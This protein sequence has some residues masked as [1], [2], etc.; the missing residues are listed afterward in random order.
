MLRH[1]AALGEKLIEIGQLYFCSPLFSIG[2]P[3][4]ALER[5][6]KFQIYCS[7]YFSRP[8]E[9]MRESTYSMPYSPISAFIM[10]LTRS[11]ARTKKH[12]GQGG[13]GA[14]I[15]LLELLTW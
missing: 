11:M 8:N 5:R 4:A 12:P 10:H 6:K 7:M 2:V 15:R 1:A 9:C 13:R 3:G 14:L